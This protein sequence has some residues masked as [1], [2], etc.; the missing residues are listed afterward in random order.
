MSVRLLVNENF[1]NPAVR[2]LRDRGVDVVAVAETMPGASDTAVLAAAREQERWLV[3]YDRDYGELVFSRRLPPPPAIVYLRQGP[4]PPSRPAEV[5]LTMI[6]DPAT[7]T[8]FFL[9]VGEQTLRRRR[10]P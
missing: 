1:P 3:T 8:G 6:A 4:Y 2:V 7:V 5:L 10:L 9:V